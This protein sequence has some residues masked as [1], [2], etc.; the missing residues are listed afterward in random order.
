MIIKYRPFGTDLANNT[1]TLSQI[2]HMIRIYC[3]FYYITSKGED[4]SDALFKNIVFF[5]IVCFSQI[6]FLF[7]WLRKIRHEI[8]VF[9][10]ARRK[11]WRTLT[12]GMVSRRAFYEEFIRPENPNTD[13]EDY[14]A[15]IG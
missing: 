14:D 8:L 15:A 7:V 2:V 3:G 1:N 13:L 11:L 9:F 10:F 12:F 6:L 5:I 4:F